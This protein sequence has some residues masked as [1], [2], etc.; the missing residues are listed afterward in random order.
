MDWNPFDCGFFRFGDTKLVQK[1]FPAQFAIE[2]PIA[3]ANEWIGDTFIGK[4]QIFQ[5]HFSTKF[6][7]V[8]LR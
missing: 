2:P 8:F 3:E 6:K 1:I 4:S 5:K 7:I